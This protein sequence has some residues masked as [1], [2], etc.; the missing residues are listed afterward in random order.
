MKIIH[1]TSLRDLCLTFV[2]SLAFLNLIL[3][4]EKLIRL[5]RLLSGSGAALIDIGKILLYIQ[6]QLLMLTIPMSLL[7]SILLVYGRMNMDSEVVV[8]RASGMDFMDMARP[9]FLLS[10]FCFFATLAVSYSIGPAASTKLR[11]TVS[12]II[13]SRSAVALEEGAFNS[14]FKDIVILIKGKE[15]PD[16]IN[17]IFIYDNR[18]KDEPRA[19]TAKQ[20]RFFS[21]DMGTI[22]LLLTHGQITISR[23]AMTT[24]L[25]F[26]KYNMLMSLDGKSPEPKKTEFTPPQLFAQAKASDTNKRKISLFLEL[27]RRFS[28]PL[29]CLALAFL[30]PPLAL[31]S[32]RSGKLGGLALGLFVF[33][34]YYMALIYGENLVKAGKMP[35]I[36]G[37]WLAP[38]LIGIFSWLMFRRER[39]R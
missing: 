6:P 29:V 11:E 31:A 17:D 23:G 18:K 30:G 27:N 26:D 7:F 33:T 19:M 32:G 1:R 22:G 21:H 8:L 24:E 35:I 13:M 16:T 15:S 39:R 9:A 2:L 25:F 37:A 38:A 10:L 12:E 20:G 3:V 5:S 14:S 4:M 28:L 36:T 34:L